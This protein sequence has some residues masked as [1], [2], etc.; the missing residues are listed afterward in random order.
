MCIFT[1]ECVCV[2][3]K[4]QKQWNKLLSLHCLGKTLRLTTKD[5]RMGKEAGRDPRIMA[6]S[7]NFWLTDLTAQKGEVTRKFKD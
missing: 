6:H 2:C 5:F 3:V 1:L 7:Q 4:M